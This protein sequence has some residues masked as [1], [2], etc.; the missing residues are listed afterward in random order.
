MATYYPCQK[1]QASNFC[2]LC[3]TVQSYSSSCTS[4]SSSNSSDNAHSCDDYCDSG[5]NSKCNTAQTICNTHSQY[6]KDHADIGAYPGKQV[7]DNDYMPN[8]WN[9]SFWNSLIDK[10][11]TAEKIGTESAQGAVE[12]TN[13]TFSLDKP[14]TATFYNTIQ[15]KFSGFGVTYAQVKVDQ[16]ITT[17]VANAIKT[18]YENAKF[19]DTVCDT[20]NT[21]QSIHAGCNCN[22]S[23]SCSCNCGCSCPCECSCPC[24]CDCGCSCSSPAT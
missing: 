15:K 3:N 10:L 16:L 22:C 20:C 7:Y 1:S 5:C 14:I 18:A 23:C 8:H 13:V 17:S 12:G 11:N 9:Q 6:I 2:N 21:D 4:S 19:K 24:D